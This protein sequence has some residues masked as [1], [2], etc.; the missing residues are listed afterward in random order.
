M[1]EKLIINFTWPYDWQNRTHTIARAITLLVARAIIAKLESNLCDY[2]Q[3]LSLGTT[4]AAASNL[5]SYFPN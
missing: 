2:T 3:T 5:C 1:D 4:A